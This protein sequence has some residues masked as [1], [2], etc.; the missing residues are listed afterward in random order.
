MAIDNHLLSVNGTM[1]KVNL[2]LI[3]E[4]K[5]TSMAQKL[6]LYPRFSPWKELKF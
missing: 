1:H 4:K 3:G 6:S 2:E 5:F